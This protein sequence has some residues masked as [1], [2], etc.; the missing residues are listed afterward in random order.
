M[1]SVIE[2]EIVIPVYNERDNII[3]VLRS[4]HRD[5]AA[6]HR[7]LLCY[8]QDDDNTIEAVRENPIEGLEIEWVKNQGRGVLGAVLSGLEQTTAAAVLVY[9]ADD[10][11]NANRIDGMLEML[12]QGCDIVA[13]SRFMRGGCMKGCPWLKA[14]IVRSSALVLRHL[15]R[16]PTCDPTNGFRL[17]SRRVIDQIPI[18]STVGFAY[19]LEFVVK[20]HRLRWRIAEAPA[21]WFERRAGPSRFKVLKWLPQYWVWFRYAFATTYLR[22]GPESVKI[23]DQKSLEK[24]Q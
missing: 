7:I 6:S 1:P 9:P 14:S 5:V 2:L 17:F 16:L 13:A 23:E 3:P 20:A 19:S 24:A 10:D 22:R 21:G 18:E 8:D 11:Y 15:A 12:R 4:L